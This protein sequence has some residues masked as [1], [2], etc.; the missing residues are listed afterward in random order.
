MFQRTIVFEYAVVFIR[1]DIRRFFLG[2]LLTANATF[3]AVACEIL[4]AVREFLHGN[5]T[6]VAA[7]FAAVR[8]GFHMEFLQF[9]QWQNRRMLLPAF[10][11]Q[12]RGTIGAHET[13]DIGTDNFSVQQFFHTAQYSVV[14]EGTTLH[15][16]MVAKFPHIF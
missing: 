11:R 4:A 8:A 3:T 7:A 10:L 14:V 9:I 16:N 5:Q 1:I 2:L 12:N 13:G 15:N 6:A